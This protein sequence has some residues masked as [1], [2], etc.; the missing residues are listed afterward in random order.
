MKRYLSLFPVSKAVGV[1]LPYMG[2]D[3]RLI[4]STLTITMFDDHCL[5]RI[6]TFCLSCQKFSCLV[7]IGLHFSS[8]NVFR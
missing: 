2:L 6:L 3:S 8:N 7:E 1:W 5:D 4:W